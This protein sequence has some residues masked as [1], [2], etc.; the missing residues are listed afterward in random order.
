MPFSAAMPANHLQCAELQKELAKC[1][2]PSVQVRH[3][4]STDGNHKITDGWVPFSC[5]S[6]RVLALCITL[7]LLMTLECNRGIVHVVS[8]IGFSYCDRPK[9]LLWKR[10]CKLNCFS[11][12]QSPLTSIITFSCNVPHFHLINAS[13]TPLMLCKDTSTFIGHSV[14]QVKP[15]MCSSLSCLSLSQVVRACWLDLEDCDR[16]IMT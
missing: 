2:L 15:R 3:S 13:L 14:V 11:Y 12:R 16:K 4:R 9:Q 10:P 6:F 1:S 8:D 5:F 7:P